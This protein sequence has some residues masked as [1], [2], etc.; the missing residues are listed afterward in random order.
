MRRRQD[1]T[2]LRIVLLLTENVYLVRL[3]LPEVYCSDLNFLA[4][5]GVVKL[6]RYTGCQMNELLLTQPLIPPHITGG[7]PEGLKRATPTSS[8][9][10]MFPCKKRIQVIR[11]G[12]E[13]SL[14]DPG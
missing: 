6:R 13:E 11:P 3:A 12:N 5:K 4:S 8:T 10:F 7:I 9:L 2:P 14:D 1:L